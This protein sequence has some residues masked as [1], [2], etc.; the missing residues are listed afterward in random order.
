MFEI[1]LLGIAYY[2]AGS[3]FDNS[4]ESAV[5]VVFILFNNFFFNYNVLE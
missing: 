5:L 2:K 3:C 1:P 4:K